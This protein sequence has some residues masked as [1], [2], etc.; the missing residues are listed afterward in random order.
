MIIDLRKS[1]KNFFV[2]EIFIAFVFLNKGFFMVEA[3]EKRRIVR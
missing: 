1:N 2:H 3:E